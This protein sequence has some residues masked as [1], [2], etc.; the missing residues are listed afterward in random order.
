L[1]ILGFEGLDKG[2][3]R[4]EVQGSRFEGNGPGLKPFLPAAIIRG[5]KAPRFLRRAQATAR[6]KRGND[7]IQGSFPFGFAQGQDDERKT[8]ADSLR[9]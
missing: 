7:E 3:E 1:G 2:M 4:F 9:E 5:A 6:A 8:E